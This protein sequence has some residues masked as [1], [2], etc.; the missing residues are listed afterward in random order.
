MVMTKYIVSLC[1]LNMLLSLGSSVDYYCHKRLANGIIDGSDVLVK[2]DVKVKS[3]VTY[4][5]LVECEFTVMNSVMMMKDV[6]EEH[7]C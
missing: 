5:F 2:V 1:L 6:I 3:N 4:G 7:R